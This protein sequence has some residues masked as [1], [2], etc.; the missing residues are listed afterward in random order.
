MASPCWMFA[1]NQPAFRLDDADRRAREDDRGGLDNAAQRRRLSATP[2]TTGKLAR[3]PPAI[4]Q[5]SCAPFVLEPV[6]R[7]D[8]EMHGHGQRQRAQRDH[9][10]HDHGDRVLRDVI[11]VG[12][13][14]NQAIHRVGDEVLRAEPLFDV[15]EITVGCLDEIRTLAAAHLDFRDAETPNRV[16]RRTA[17]ELRAALERIERA[18]VD[19]RTRVGHAFHDASQWRSG[20]IRIRACR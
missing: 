18:I 1:S 9:I 17:G 8:A 11:V 3:L 20:Q 6:G 7:A 10:V 13:R 14:R 12:T 15:R 19:A 5:V 16:G 2:R 4:D